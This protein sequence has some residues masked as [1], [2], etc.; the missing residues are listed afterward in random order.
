M[1]L[2]HDRIKDTDAV[3]TPTL[4]QWIND[5]RRRAQ[6][7]IEDEWGEIFVIEDGGYR[8]L[9]FDAFYE[10]SKMRLSEPSFPVFNYTKA[11]LLAVALTHCK[12]VLHLGLGAGSLVRA[13]HHIDDRITQHIVE[14]RPSVIEIATKYFAL[15]VSEHINIRRDDAKRYLQQSVMQHDIIFADLFWSM[16]MEP[17]QT[18]EVFIAQCRQQLN[19][20]GWLVI[21]YM[22][23]TDINDNLL[24][25]LFHYFDD[26][27]LCVIP[28]GNAII[29]AGS[30]VASGGLQKLYNNLPLLEA[31]LSCKVSVL[32]RRLRRLVEPK[33]S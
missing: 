5:T 27:L 24:S 2:T 32:A 16:R 21:N 11:M 20:A 9:M 3:L 33:R 29:F 10:Q 6:L 4:T 30:L 15:P 22:L 28:N 12:S 17:L 14:I 13:L 26:I 18:Q 23:E 19:K 7:A 1:P 25:N 31:R 8:A